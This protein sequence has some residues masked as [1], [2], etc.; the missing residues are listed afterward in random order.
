MSVHKRRGK[1]FEAYVVS[2]IV[3]QATSNTLRDYSLLGAKT[4]KGSVIGEALHLFGA[5]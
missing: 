1:K 2:R 5:P 4:Q 3:E